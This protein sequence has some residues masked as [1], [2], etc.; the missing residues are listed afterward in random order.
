MIVCVSTVSL[1]L[2]VA[3]LEG[4]VGRSETLGSLMVGLDIHTG[5]PIAIVQSNLDQSLLGV[6]IK[7]HESIRIVVVADNRPLP[8]KSM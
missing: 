3:F 2:S 5:E 6:P 4:L 8:E 1:A 7:R